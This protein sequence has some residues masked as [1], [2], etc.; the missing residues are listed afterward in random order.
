MRE[1]PAKAQLIDIPKLQIFIYAAEA[2]SFSKAA[3]RS[4]LTQPTVSHHIKTLEVEIGAELFSR[5]GNHL[6]LT[7]AGRVLLPRA[8]QLMRQATTLQELIDSINQE[9]IIGHLRIACGA[10][11]GKY[12]LP[13]LAARFRQQHP[14]VKISIFRCAPEFI[15]SRL[16]EGEANLGLLSYEIDTIGLE[17]KEFIKDQISL[18]VPPIHPWAQ[19]EMI[20]PE[21]LISEPIIMREIASGTRRAMLSALAKFDISVDDLNIFL[22]LGS[23]E[24]II[25]TVFEGYGISFVSRVAT[26]YK[27]SKKDIVEVAVEGLDLTRSIYIVRKEIEPP[28]RAQEVFWNFFHS[29]KN[30]DLL[31]LSI[32]P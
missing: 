20:S 30:A 22:E 15:L 23:A 11:A 31:S 9:Q 32:S 14:G 29:P 12:L 3:K 27:R 26:A 4:N 17:I 28:N 6:H 24:A 16:F 13:K 5:A 18:V 2:L 7:E 1:K 21:D 25:E 19:A 8:R 10:T